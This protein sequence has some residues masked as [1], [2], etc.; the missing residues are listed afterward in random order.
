MEKVINYNNKL[1][2]W[3]NSYIRTEVTSPT[4]PAPSYPTDSL[5]ARWTLDN[6]A[7]SSYSAIEDLTWEAEAG[8]IS[9]SDGGMDFD[10]TLWCSCTT[11]SAYT[12]QDGNSA[13]TVS[14]WV[15]LDT[16]ANGIGFFAMSTDENLTYTSGE[17]ISSCEAYASTGT[18][19]IRARRYLWDSVQRDVVSS[20]YTWPV[21]WAHY[22]YKFD[23]AN[24]Y[25]YADNVAKGSSSFSGSLSSGSDT[26]V[27]GKG[28]DG[29]KMNGRIKYV[30]LYSKALSNEEI[31]QLYNSG[32]P[33]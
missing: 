29:A 18:N 10:G 22:V 9:Y 30:Y 17:P 4:A 25:W 3:N 26:F 12:V 1:L 7:V 28:V 31:A 6:T 21:D 2:T 15:S 19:L 8:T 14:L 20:S 16:Y 24:M 11:D 5:F 23:G 27:L 33:I 13:W 32:T